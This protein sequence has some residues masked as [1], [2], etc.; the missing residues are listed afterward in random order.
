[1]YELGATVGYYAGEYRRLLPASN[2][3]DTIVRYAQKRDT[4][5]RPAWLALWT[6][7][8]DGYH[9]TIKE[10]FLA[11]VLPLKKVFERKGEHSRVSIYEIPTPFDPLDSN[12]VPSKPD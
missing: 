12:S 5:H 9:P 7:E 6:G 2:D 3:L 1:M 4:A 10:P 8:A 11:D